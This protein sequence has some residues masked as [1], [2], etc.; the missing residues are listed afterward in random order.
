MVTGKVD[1]V[2][3][4]KEIILPSYRTA[5]RPANALNGTILYNSDTAKLNARLN[6][7]WVEVT[8]A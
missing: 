5:A 2:V 8:S 7:S 4:P 3:I 1:D 6:G